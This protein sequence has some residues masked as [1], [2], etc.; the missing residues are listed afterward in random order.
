MSLLF[1]R[2]FETVQDLNRYRKELNASLQAGGGEQP[3]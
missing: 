3:A 2:T 1:E